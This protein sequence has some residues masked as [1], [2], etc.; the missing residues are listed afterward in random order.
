MEKTT[1]KVLETADTLAKAIAS[2]VESVEF[3]GA[4]SVLTCTLGRGSDCLTIQIGGQTLPLDTPTAKAAVV[5]TI[6]EELAVADALLYREAKLAAQAV[7]R[8]ESP[9]AHSLPASLVALTA[10]SFL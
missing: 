5:F 9:K 4:F 1:E 2:G 3:S 6:L 10:I 8:G 7:D